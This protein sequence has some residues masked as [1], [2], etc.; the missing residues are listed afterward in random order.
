MNTDVMQV[1]EFCI[2]SEMW[3]VEG[4]DLIRKFW[5]ADF[6]NCSF[7][8]LSHMWDKMVAI[9]VNT[10]RLVTTFQRI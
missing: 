9:L 10:E 8:I 3:E 7:A 1:L 4:D 2:K 6:L 5:R